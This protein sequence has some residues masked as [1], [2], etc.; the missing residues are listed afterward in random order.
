MTERRLM[1]ILYAALFT[2]EPVIGSQNHDGEANYVGYERVLF[3]T[4]G[5]ENIERITFP[6]CEQS[7]ETP[8]THVAAID[9]SGV[10][11]GVIALMPA[12]ECT[13]IAHTPES[14]TIQSA[15]TS[16]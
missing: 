13:R 1:T 2:K 10:I 8:I 9:G 12:V 4:D 14:H 3:V 7:Y 15:S 11:V 16:G 6:E 5:R